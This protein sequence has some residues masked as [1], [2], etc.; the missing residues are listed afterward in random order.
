[1]YFFRKTTYQLTYIYTDK[2]FIR[3]T[4][5]AGSAHW[6]RPPAAPRNCRC[7]CS[8]RMGGSYRDILHGYL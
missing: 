2:Y 6:H 5:S 3:A 7:S 8:G 4:Q 1:L